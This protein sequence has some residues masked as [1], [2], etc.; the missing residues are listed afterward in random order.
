M[1]GIKETYFL[2]RLDNEQQFFAAGDHSAF[3]FLLHLHLHGPQLLL[4]ILLKI[5]CSNFNKGSEPITNF[6]IGLCNFIT[7]F[8]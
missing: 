8:G 6:I 3:G 2:V 1:N 7:Y 4:K 5:N